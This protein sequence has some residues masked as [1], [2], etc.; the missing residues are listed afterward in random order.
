MIIKRHIV[1]TVAAT[2]FAFTATTAAFAHAHLVRATPAAGGTV[3]DA[4]GEVVLRFNEKL[5][6]AF[7]TVVVR[8]AAGKQVDKA[9]GQVDKADHTVMKVSLQPLTPGV[10][11]VEWRALSTDTH[12]SNGDFAFTISQ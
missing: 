2:A 6:T 3:H 5:E 7:S 9:D 11:K 10:Y 1:A 8:D 4:P 12:K